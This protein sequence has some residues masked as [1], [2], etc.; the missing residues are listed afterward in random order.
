[1]E[2]APLT[3]PPEPLLTFS[4]IHVFTGTIRKTQH[5]A[6]AH[7]RT[8]ILLSAARKRSATA[9]QRKREAVKPVEA[10]VADEGVVQQLRESEEKIMAMEA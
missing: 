10:G 1:M 8:Q 5:A 4:L 7:D 6:I 2:L 9:R 3:S